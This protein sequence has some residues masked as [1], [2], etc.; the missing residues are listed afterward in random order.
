VADYTAEKLPEFIKSMPSYR[1]GKLAEAL[2]VAFLQFDGTLIQDEVIEALKELAG[3][4]A[5][6]EEGGMVF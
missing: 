3:M 1:D 5:E 6:D 2:E 4:N